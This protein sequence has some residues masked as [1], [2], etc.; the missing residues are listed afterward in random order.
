MRSPA[1]SLARLFFLW[2]VYIWTA[3]IDLR[4]ATSA[5]QADPPPY[6]EHNSRG[7]FRLVRWPA[8]GRGDSRGLIA[9]RRPLSHCSPFIAA[10]RFPVCVQQAAAAGAPS[11]LRLEQP[12]EEWA[13]VRFPRRRRLAQ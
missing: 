12:Q 7:A 10:L 1:C 6:C 4:P 3:T 5:S 9:L 11:F 2:A 13:Q 8:A